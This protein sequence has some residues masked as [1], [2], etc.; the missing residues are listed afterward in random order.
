MSREQGEE[1]SRK[2]KKETAPE[3]LEL[4]TFRLTYITV[5]RCDQLSH[6]AYLAWHVLDIH[7]GISRSF[8]KKKVN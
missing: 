8:P 5:G 1:V 7:G 3:R 6:G 4:S 2:K